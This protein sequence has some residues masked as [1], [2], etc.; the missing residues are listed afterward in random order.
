[1]SGETAEE[2]AKSDSGGDVNI[3]GSSPSWYPK[4][5]FVDGGG[6]CRQIAPH[7]RHRY[8]PSPIF[9]TGSWQ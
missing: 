7:V 2:R 8:A 3:H 5:A 6:F 4:T 1:V 9:S